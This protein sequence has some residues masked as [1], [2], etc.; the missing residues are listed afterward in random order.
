M[1]ITIFTSGTTGEQKVVTHDETD[2]YK[3][4]QFLCNKWELTKSDVILNP[5][6]TWTIANWAFCVFPAQLSGCE[7]VNIKMNPFKFW[8]IIEELKPTVLTLAIGTF[9]T[10]IK[11][12]IPNLDFV[13]NLSTGSAPIFQSDLSQLQSTKATN[14]WN[15][16]GSTECIPPVVMSNNDEFDFKDS[17]YYLEYDET[18]IVNGFNTE[19]KFEHNKCLSRLIVNETWKN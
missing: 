4:A 18:L 15:I 7:V 13:R 6:P 12:R 14:I 10:L 9:R 3:P 2:F 8:D 11:R 19:D 17:P 1:K 5:F 16:Y